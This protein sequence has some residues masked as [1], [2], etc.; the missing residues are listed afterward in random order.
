MAADNG[1]EELLRTVGF[2]N[3]KSNFQA[4]QQ[5]DEAL[6]RQSEWLRI[7]LESIGDAVISTDA[8]GR[9][10]FLNGV[11]ERLTGW[12]RDEGVGRPLVEVFQ[13]INE[14]TRQP[15]E[16]PA[17]RALE[18]GAVMGLANHTVLIA[19]DGTE[20]PIDDSAAPI[21]DE[22]GAV[23]GVVLVFRDITQRREAEAV[24]RR[25]H[26]AVEAER[27]RLVELLDLSPA[28][29]A[30][31]KGPNHVYEHVNARYYQ[32][33]GQRELIGKPIR[34]AIPEI[35]WQDN[36]KLFDQVY[37]TGQP[38]VGTDMRV[39]LRREPDGPLEE[40][41]ISF[42]YQPLRDAEG[43]VCGILSHGIDLTDR[44]RAE[45]D[46]AYRAAIVESSQDAIVGKTLDGQILSWNAGAE[47]IFG[48]RANE[49]IGRSITMIIPAERLD[50]E[51]MIL[52]RIR[53]GERVE[54]FETVRVTKDGRQVD[55]S[56][57]VSPVRDRGGRIVGVS[58]IARDITDRRKSEAALRD[59]D[60]R[61][62]HFIALLAHELRN[63]LAALGNSLNVLRL[64]GGDAGLTA[65]TRALMERQHSHM[66]R[67]VDDLLD[68]AR[69]SQ[70][71]IELRRARVQLADVLSSAVETVRPLIDSAGHT[72]TVSLPQ[73][74]VFLDADLTRLAQVFGNLLANSAKY[75]PGGG[76]I[77]LSA[78]RH[79]AEVAVIVRDTGD[80]I[81]RD[82]LPHI[83]DMFSQV[84]RPAA[85]STGGLG[86]GLALVKGLVELHR[87]T[88]TAESEG[89]GRGS[90]FTVRLPILMTEPLQLE[91]P[92]GEDRSLTETKRRILVVDDNRDAGKSLALMLTLMGNSVQTAHTGRDAIAIAQRWCP[93]IVLM[94][95]GMPD[96]DGYETT[97]CIREQPGG[98]DM[99]ILAL[100]GWGQE[101]DRIR[102]REAGCNGHLVKPVGYRDLEKML[103]EVASGRSG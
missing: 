87:G 22:T 40:R 55:I 26:E 30:V 14:H 50:E 60:R 24:R 66:V 92:E 103:S 32:F 1:E 8:D 13:I 39:L 78:E 5:A 23:V 11:A 17:L 19:R 41:F 102:S 9:V 47:R 52:E 59:A 2:P 31:L 73:P 80:G 77:W 74:P 20:R 53:R 43:A 72:L 79:G 4:Q 46:Q 97:R 42:V 28:Y 84:E 57:T 88:V 64:A 65:P 29:T 96:L 68:V 12:P 18:V 76:R 67:L 15:V 34:E 82:A 86:I 101:S 83:F 69:I 70:N 98:R 21:R 94:D 3:A 27:A 35:E 95:V 100:T 6:R 99:V 7:T 89:Q 36:I 54:H 16:N 90:T 33:V 91:H 93:E 37:R 49:A 61:K 75:T 62:E 81:P 58:K 63:P 25:A 71:K 10:T 38:Y 48:Y 51:R 44:K 45:E 56:L 85:R